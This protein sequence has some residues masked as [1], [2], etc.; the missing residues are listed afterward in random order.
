MIAEVTT[1]VSYLNAVSA[2][3]LLV[4]IGLAWLM[5]SYRSQVNW[6]L[7]VKGV[8]LQGTLGA[9]LFSSQNWT[10]GGRFEDGI[11]FS[12]MD[13][14]FS[15]IKLWTDQGA[16]FVFNAYENPDLDGA[17]APTNPAILIRSF[18]FGVIPTVIFFSALM[19]VLYY[20]GIMQRVVGMMA[21]GMQKTLGTTGPESLA[22]AANVFVGHTEAPLVIRPYIS[23]MTRSELNALM[24]GGFA[25]IT[26]G[27][28]AV[29][30][31]QFQVS[32]GHLVV[33]SIISAPAALVIAKILQ[34]EV[35]QTDDS[36][37][38]KAMSAA[39]PVNVVEAAA[40][41]ASE[42]V[43]LAINIIGMLIAFLA[44]IA[45]CDTLLGVLGEGCQ[46]LVNSM[47]NARNPVD[48]HWS[49]NELLGALFYPIAWIMGIE[50]SDCKISAQLLGRKMVANEF[51]A[52][53][54]LGTIIKGSGEGVSQLSERT[55]L[56]M[57]YALCGFS[58]FGAI[59]IQL[60]GIGGL[61]PE[62]RGELA[63]LGLRAMLGGA[64]ACSMTAC[65][66]G[67]LFGLLH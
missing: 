6:S 2:V 55:I 58:N 47:R 56:I 48:F 35:E 42:G 20:L 64:L 25:T 53:G 5:S 22:A 34:P 51:I 1:S 18:A 44:L 13:G 23:S 32:A 54:D 11:L 30:V 31:T 19:S 50:S 33:A 39:P 29:F 41:G 49:L 40:V 7:V 28:M 62:R 43:K 3:G 65:V 12:L 9:I 38:L 67:A 36:H 61:A 60:G 27:L 37:I 24:V 8:L 4:M 21:F 59:G 66:A 45:M 63:Q 14:F 52:Y 15:Y 57:T 10:F 26:G 46:W 16:S 17:Y